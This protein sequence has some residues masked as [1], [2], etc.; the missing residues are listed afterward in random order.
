[1]QK[2]KNFLIILTGIFISLVSIAPA[3]PAYAAIK[4][5]IQA[6][7]CGAAGQ[8]SCT[9]QTASNSLGKTIKQIVNLLSV[10]A[11]V[12][13]VIM[14]IVSGLRY[15]TSA[16]NDQAVAGAKKSILYALV[17][18]AIVAFA[19]VIVRFVLKNVT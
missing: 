19:Q 6:G 3:T 8:P 1:M 7:A 17:G 5:D 12:I 13:A 16:G 9:P 10:V 18:L 2:I 4:D 11:G 14:L 15:V